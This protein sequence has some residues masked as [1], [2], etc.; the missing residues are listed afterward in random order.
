MRHFLELYEQKPC[1]WNK[2]VCHIKT[3][4]REIC[5]ESATAHNSE[6]EVSTYFARIVTLSE[7]VPSMRDGLLKLL[8]IILNWVSND[9]SSNNS[10]S[11]K[12]LLK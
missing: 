1:L 11:G 3:E 6:H 7:I 8:W 9:A 2:N 10:S 12:I 5:I 4:I